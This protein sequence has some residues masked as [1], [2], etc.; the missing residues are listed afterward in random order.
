LGL[1]LEA[2]DSKGDAGTD[3]LSQT[4]CCELLDLL[5]VT[6]DHENG[7]ADSFQLGPIDLSLGRGELVFIGHYAGMVVPGHDPEVF[8][9]FP[10]PGNG[11]ARLD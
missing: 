7:S 8:V 2:Q 4:A 9:K 1:S 6:H 3:D 5:S 10:K 11:V